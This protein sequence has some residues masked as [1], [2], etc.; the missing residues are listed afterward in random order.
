MRVV[1]GGALTVAVGTLLLTVAPG[2]ARVADAAL[3]KLASGSVDGRAAPASRAARVGRE[4]LALPVFVRPTVPPLV[5]TL[6]QGLTGY[7]RFD[8]SPGSETAR[9]LSAGQRDCTLH[10]VDADRGWLPGALGGGLDVGRGW[11][12]CPQP[13]SVLRGNT[14][15]TVSAWVRATEFPRTGF[16]A[17][18]A[19]QLSVDT[20]DYFFLGL[21]GRRLVA[22]GR[23]WGAGATASRELPRGQWV[24]IA[25]TRAADGTLRLYQDGALVGSARRVAR[26]RPHPIDT[27]L[28]I[29][30]DLNG[31]ENTRRGQQLKGAVD[32]V[33]TYDRALPPEQIAAL[34][35][36]VQPP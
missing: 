26:D 16:S 22:S 15:I 34:A 18:V 12:Q 1:L 27:P 8:E 5:A 20:R 31:P 33:L 21:K 6:A 9:D 4:R 17:V 36:G 13:P 30:S 14:E 32:E 28:T 23:Y 19:R 3:A 35:A 11:L 25:F 10:D 7:W 24:H 29:G 2:P